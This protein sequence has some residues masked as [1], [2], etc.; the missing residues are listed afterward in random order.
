MHMIVYTKDV[1]FNCLIFVA[2]PT[3]NYRSKP[4]KSNL[5]F[6]IL[7]IEKQVPSKLA[8]LTS[9]VSYVCDIIISSQVDL[10]SRVY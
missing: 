6:T 1:K 2:C 3:K 8:L 4:R 7:N 10:S 5:R 9:C